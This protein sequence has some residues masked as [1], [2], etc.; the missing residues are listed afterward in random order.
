MQVR[1]N[2]H[3]FH[4]FLQENQDVSQPVDLAS[5]V[6]SVPEDCSISNPACFGPAVLWYFKYF[7]YYTYFNSSPLGQPCSGIAV[8]QKSSNLVVPRL[9]PELSQVSQL[10]HCSDRRW[11]LGRDN[12]PSL[13]HLAGIANH[14]ARIGLLGRT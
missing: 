6:L 4:F 9:W 5:L 10:L 12:Q 11:I 7:K 2:V 14:V 3:L 13:G 8:L 1:R